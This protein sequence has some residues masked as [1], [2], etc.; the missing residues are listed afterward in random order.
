MD[1][2]I[3]AA[4]KTEPFHVGVVLTPGFSLMAF[5]SIVEPLRGANLIQGDVLYRWSHMSPDGGMVASGGGLEVQT[6]PLPKL[7]SADLHMM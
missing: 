6:E 5:A 3:A 1:K 7:P 4:A 2:R